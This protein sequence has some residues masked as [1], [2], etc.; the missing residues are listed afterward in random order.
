ML[1]F[2]VA[3]EY[4]RCVDDLDR[5]G[6][7]ARL[8]RSKKRGIVGFDGREHPLPTLERV[9]GLFDR[10]R[11][12]VALKVS[13]GFDRL[14][15]TPLA[16]SLSDLVAKTRASILERAAEGTVCRS[17]RSPKDPFVPVRVNK[18]K[19]VW[20]WETLRRAFDSDDLVY[21]PREYSGDHGGLTKR[22]AVGDPRICAVPGWSVGLAESVR[23]IPAPG[24]GRTRG[25]RRQIESGLSPCE[26]LDLLKGD[27]YRGE[28]GPTLEDFLV[29]FLTRLRETGE[30]GR[31]VEDANALWCLGQYMKISY[32]E[33]VPAAR[34][35]RRLGR[36]RLDAHRTRNR[37]CAWN[38]GAATV[39]RLGGALT[40]ES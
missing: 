33:I 34:W 21:F 13:Q 19:Q 35:I 24:S 29:E 23:F 17:R 16:I 11:D 32:A 15:L 31:E 5:A 14:L 39:V 6:L 8:P 22:Q 3:R 2:P 28:T 30:V 40:S 9:T 25:G 20:I 36:L 1:A 4:R 10:H 38:V 26:Y 27:A 12:F 7:L 37:K 18:E